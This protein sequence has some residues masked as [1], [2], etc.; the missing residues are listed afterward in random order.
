MKDYYND[1]EYESDEEEEQDYDYER[2]YAKKDSTKL[3]TIIQISVCC[4]I[5]L[6][7]I[8]LRVSGGNAYN[9]IRS[10]YVQKV[11]QTIIPDE[12]IQNVKEKVVELFPAVSNELPLT[13]SNSRQTQSGKNN[14]ESQ[15]AAVSQNNSSA[16]QQTNPQSG[17]QSRQSDSQAPAKSALPIQS[18]A[19]IG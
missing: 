15:Q 6:T 10:W 17:V 5:L 19:L 13:S 3:L 12:Q 9:T 11:N 1:D 14:T 8:F 18:Q 7:M 2:R 16:A 4:V